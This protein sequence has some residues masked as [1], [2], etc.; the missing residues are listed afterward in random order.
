LVQG[1]VYFGSMT[2]VNVH[3]AKTQLSQLL[4]RVLAGEE[5]VIA[6]NGKPLVRLAPVEPKRLR[7]LGQDQGLFEVPEDFDDPLPPEVLQGFGL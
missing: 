2:L 5:I 7:T 4:T 6:R 1:L 3:E